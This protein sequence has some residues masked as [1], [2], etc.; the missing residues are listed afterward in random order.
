MSSDCQKVG[1]DFTL[2][3]AVERYDIAEGEGTRD[4]SAVSAAVTA[5]K[6]RISLASTG[7]HVQWTIRVKYG[8]EAWSLSKRFSQVAALHEVLK[9]RLPRLPE[10]PSK[11]AVRQFSVEYLEGRKAALNA[12]FLELSKRRDVLNCVEAQRFFGLPDHVEAFRLPH[13][14][15]PVQIA[16]V[17]ESTFSVTSFAYDAAQGV[18]VLGASD[19]SWT[20][21]MDTKITNIKLPWE[22]AAPNLPSSQMS[23]WR[24]TPADLR[25]EMQATCRYPHSISCVTVML[26][27]S[28]KGLCFCGLGDGTVGTHPLEGEVGIHNSGATLPLLKHT[29]GVAALAVDEAEH[30]IISASKDCGLVVYSL[31]RQMLL[32][33]VQT[34]APP[35]AM[36][37]ESA[38]KRLFCALQ[39]GRVAVWDTTILPIKQVAAIP[40]GVLDPASSAPLAALDFDAST[41]TLFTAS[42]AGVSL[43]AVKSSATGAWGRKAGHIAGICER[44]TAILWAESSREL[45]VGFGSGAVVIYDIESGISSYAIQAHQEAITGMMWL[46]APRRL[47][48]SSVDKSLKLWDFPSLMRTPLEG[49]P[50]FATQTAGPPPNVS[51]STAFRDRRPVGAAAAAF[52]GAFAAA[53]APAQPAG[54][55]I[56]A[57]GGAGGYPAAPAAARPEAPAAAAAARAAG[58]KPSAAIRKEDSD[59]DLAGWDS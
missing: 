55:A 52:A 51:I 45:L 16:E 40:D 29:A 2:L 41:G 38:S 30:W 21:R 58:A 24:Q 17:Q 6:A 42:S 28:G 47:L 36:R 15:E 9:P 56:R 25:F 46:D 19:R 18:L 8:R 37:Y 39:N 48:T 33:S 59:D 43:W 31:K 13:A 54:V 3:V 44:P 7:Q 26:P 10:L 57:A 11:S 1:R 20:S 22:P 12:Y 35:T 34:P 5:L 23:I 50:G 32:C 14:S 27:G 49:Q 53:P 4:T